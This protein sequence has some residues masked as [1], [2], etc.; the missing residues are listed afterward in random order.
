[1]I[2]A[3]AFSGFCLGF[4]AGMLMISRVNMRPGLKRVL[5]KHGLIKGH[6]AR[7]PKARHM[8]ENPSFLEI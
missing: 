2:Y 8:T 7:V 3:I 4:A 1:M 6:K 5:M